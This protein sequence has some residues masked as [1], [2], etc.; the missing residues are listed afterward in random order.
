MNTLLRYRLM[1]F[2]VVVYS[3]NALA[4]ATVAALLNIS[5]SELSGTKRF[6]IV[7]GII[8]NWSGTMLAL[9]NK[10]RAELEHKAP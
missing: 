2:Y 6:L 5:W 10:A 4:T 8:G 3:L 7:V 9:F 1:I